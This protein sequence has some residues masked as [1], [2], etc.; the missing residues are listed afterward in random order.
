AKDPSHR[1]QDARAMGEDLR[2]AASGLPLDSA[3]SGDGGRPAAE[4]GQHLTEVLPQGR[5][6]VLS[7][8]DAT[9]VAD[10]SAPSPRRRGTIVA[11]AILGGVALHALILALPL[12]GGGDEAPSGT[13]TPHLASTPAD[14]APGPAATPAQ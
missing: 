1:Y 14:R 11:G 6:A 12:N 10:R 4:P 9:T 7:A 8:A 5:K 3:P 13:G 2:R